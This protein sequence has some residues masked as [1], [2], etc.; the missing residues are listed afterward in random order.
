MSKNTDAIQ[1]AAALGLVCRQKHATIKT[2][3]TRMALGGAIGGGVG[4]A[5]FGA[6][7]QKRTIR[8][9]RGIGAGTGGVLGSLAGGA[10]GS[11]LPLL[12]GQ[13]QSE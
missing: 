10:A 4:G 5:G 1:F 13:S 7:I 11:L 2:A 6:G 3:N 8:N 9:A 12:L